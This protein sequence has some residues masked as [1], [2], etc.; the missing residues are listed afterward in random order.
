MAPS[1]TQDTGVALLAEVIGVEAL[2]FGYLSC[3]KKGKA[4]V[5]RRQAVAIRFRLVLQHIILKYRSNTVGHDVT[6]A[7][8]ATPLCHPRTW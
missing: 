7:V 2:H 1:A 3:S 5:K 6:D 4:R 8:T